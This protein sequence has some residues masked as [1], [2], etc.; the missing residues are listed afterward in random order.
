MRE[1]QA[2]DAPAIAKYA[3]NWNVAQNLTDGFPFP[4]TAK[5]AEGYIHFCLHEGEDRQCVRAIE[6]GGKAVGS[7]GFFLKDDIRCKTAELGYWLGEP[8][9]GNGIMSRAIVQMRDYAFANYDI[10]RM[11]AEP[12]AH[13]AGSRR[14]LEKTGFTLEGILQKSVCK[15]GQIFDSCI[16]AYTE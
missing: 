7:I 10:I 13:N 8:F 4:Y 1:W 15:W 6:I 5:D 3:N 11:Y 2:N 9:W 12:F 14:A 16:Y